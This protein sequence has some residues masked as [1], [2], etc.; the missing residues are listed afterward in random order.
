MGLV[1]DEHLNFVNASEELEELASS[2]QR[3]L[4]A[5]IYKYKEFKDMGFNTY[6]TLFNS[7]VL[8]ILDYCCPVWSHIKTSKIEQVQHRAM[9]VYMGVKRFAPFLGFMGIWACCHR[10]TDK[11]W[12]I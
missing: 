1:L 7:G 8:P 12:K 5:I 11:C 2:G 9:Q 10:N 4:G 6:T 3:A